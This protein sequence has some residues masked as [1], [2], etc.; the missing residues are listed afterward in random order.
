MKLKYYDRMLKHGAQKFNLVEPETLAKCSR[1]ILQQQTKGITLM[2]S[3][4]R[5]L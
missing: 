4:H 5:Q 2:E 3:P 1:D